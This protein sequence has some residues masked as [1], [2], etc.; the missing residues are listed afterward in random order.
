MQLQP[1]KDFSGGWRMRISLARALFV[2]PDLLLLD[3]VYTHLNSS[4]TLAD[5]PS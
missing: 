2:A 4:Y 3:E 5:K 1:T